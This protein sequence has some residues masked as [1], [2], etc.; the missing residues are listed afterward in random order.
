MTEFGFYHL[1]TTSL[2]AALPRVLE[3]VHDLG[4]R[5]VVVAGS[6]QRVEML[7]AALWTYKQESFLPHG[8]A[9]DGRAAE[10]PIWLTHLDEN[11]NGARVVVLTD[12]AEVADPLAYERCFH[13][14]DGR[15]EAAVAQAR[16]RYKAA[17]DGG[18]RLKY[19]RQTEQGWDVKG[20]N[21][22]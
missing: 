11:P 12:G 16:L 7:N 19:F 8:S 17:L 6:P 3:K 4:L 14:F 22:A 15:N 20:A 9:P 13:F 2:E 18:H 1:L 5:A 21:G 10:Q